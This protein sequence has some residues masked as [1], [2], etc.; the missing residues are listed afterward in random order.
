MSKASRCI[1]RRVRHREGTVDEK[2]RERERER[3]REI[4]KLPLSVCSVQGWVGIGE[5][6]DRRSE[7]RQFREKPGKFERV[8]PE[9]RILRTTGLALRS[10]GGSGRSD[11]TDHSNCT[12]R[13]KLWLGKRS[14]DKR[15]S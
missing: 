11:S 14:F 15:F 8:G 10:C 3:E 4:L 12:R 1:N 6:R 2:E 5:N 7:M 9:R 13:R